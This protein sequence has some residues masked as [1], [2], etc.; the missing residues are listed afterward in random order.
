MMKSGV[1]VRTLDSLPKT[2]FVKIL[3]GGIPLLGKFIPKITNFSDFGR[4]K[5]DNGEIWPEGT[6]LGYPP[7]A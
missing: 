3:S 7:C 2:I 6:D 1:R 5:S 4:F